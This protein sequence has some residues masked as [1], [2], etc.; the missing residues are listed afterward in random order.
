M[1]YSNSEKNFF[2][3][4]PEDF[5]IHNLKKK[6][7]FELCLDLASLAITVNSQSITKLTPE[8]LKEIDNIH[9]NFFENIFYGF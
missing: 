8:E 2:I 6:Y 7:N 1:P 4:H 9:P 5:M 3:I